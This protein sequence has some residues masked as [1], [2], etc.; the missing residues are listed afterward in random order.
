MQINTRSPHL[1]SVINS[2]ELDIELLDAVFQATMLAG[3][4]DE[5]DFIRQPSVSFN[6]RPARVALILIKNCSCHNEKIIAAGMLASVAEFEIASLQV[7]QESLKI[8]LAAKE[9]LQ[10]NLDAQL[11][12]PVVQVALAAW[13]DRI[14][15]I[16][17]ASEQNV[18]RLR[19]MSVERTRRFLPIATEHA[20]QL[21]NLLKHWLSRSER[22]TKKNRS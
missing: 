8:A 3:G 15:H 14:R 5:L 12:T 1:A 9:F 16:H 11:Q 7:E 20:P 6:P 13:L 22:A 10:N 2:L 18:D 19:A 21:A 17:L 4:D